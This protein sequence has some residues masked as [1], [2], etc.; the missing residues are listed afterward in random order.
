MDDIEKARR[1]MVRCWMA[2]GGKLSARTGWRSVMKSTDPQPAQQWRDV[3]NRIMAFTDRLQGV[4][5]ENQHAIEITKRYKLPEVLIYADP[6]YVLET[7]SGTIYRHEMN[8][9]DHIQLLE[10]LDD[11]PGPVFLS[12]YAH[13]LYDDRLKHWRRETR[14]SLAQRGKIAEEVLWINPVAAEYAGRQLTLF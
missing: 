1:F 3:P 12:G 10:A 2:Q 14:P 9:D 13:P 8:T 7:R 5:V 11:H 4:Q 6:P